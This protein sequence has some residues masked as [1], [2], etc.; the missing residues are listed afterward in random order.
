MIRSIFCI[1]ASCLPAQ[2]QAHAGHLGDLA[3]HAHWIGLAA[4]ALAGAI[5]AGLLHGKRGE[6]PEESADDEIE[7]QPA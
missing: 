5:A 7:E 2:V 1:F 3:G 4:I 6:K